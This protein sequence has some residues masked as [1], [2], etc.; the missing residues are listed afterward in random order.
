MA[1]TKPSSRILRTPDDLS[2]AGLI[3]KRRAGAL[4]DVARR[5]AVAVT[6]DMAELIDRTDRRDPIA[7]QF[8]PDVAELTEMQGELADPIGDEAHSPVKG[9]VHRYPDR[10]LLKP[11]HACPVYCR[12]CFRRE[13]VGPGKD[14]L[15]AA[16]LDAALAYIRSHREIWEVILTGG[17]PLMLSARRLGAI[18]AALARVDHVAVVRIHTRVPVAEPTRVTAALVRA[19]KSDKAVYVAIHCNH[20]RELTAAARRACRMLAD[21]GI[22]LLSQ[23]VLLKGVNDDAETLETLLRTLVANRIKPYYLHHPDKARGTARFRTTVARGQ[24]LMRRLRGRVSGLC[25]P[26]YVLDLPGGYGKVPI[27]PCHVAASDAQDA[28]VIEDY[29]GRRRIYRE[30]GAS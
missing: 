5:F 19:L 3:E 24:A 1:I 15:S 20:A 21:A 14:L 8:V 2:S 27:G 28:L 25:Q 22:P 10:V 17:D 13:M 30:D 29:K 9:I 11:L 23:T 26:S 12:F 4:E 16:E 7:R 6:P 18:M